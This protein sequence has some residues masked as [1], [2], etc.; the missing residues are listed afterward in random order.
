MSQTKMFKEIQH[1]DFCIL[2]CV[3]S[4]PGKRASLRLCAV[5]KLTNWSKYSA[6]ARN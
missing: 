1:A 3:S 2:P 6:Q 5:S 4:N